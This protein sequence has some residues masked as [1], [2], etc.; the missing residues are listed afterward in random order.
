MRKHLILL[1][2][3][4]IFINC[5]RKIE[6]NKLLLD[7]TIENKNFEYLYDISDFKEEDYLGKLRNMKTVQ[8]DDTLKVN[9]EILEGGAIDLDGD[10]DIINDTLILKIIRGVGVREIFLNEY[11]Y[12]IL[13]RTNNKYKLKLITVSK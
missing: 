3:A 2:I 4:S 12:S 5:E 7:F 13:N 9:F 11:S 10:I 8:I 6:K 1:V